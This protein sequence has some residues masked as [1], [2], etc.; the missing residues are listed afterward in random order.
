MSKA[1]PFRPSD[2]VIELDKREQPYQVVHQPHK[3]TF[4]V[5]QTTPAFG[6]PPQLGRLLRAD[7][8]SGRALDVMIDRRDYQTA[9]ESLAFRLGNTTNAKERL[10]TLAKEASWVVDHHLSAQ[11]YQAAKNAPGAPSKIRPGSKI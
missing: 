7:Q 6:M 3:I 8:R 4:F 1:N 5:Y 2:Y 10:Q 9:L 11:A